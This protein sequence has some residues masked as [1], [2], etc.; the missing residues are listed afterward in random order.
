MVVA[1]YIRKSDPI[2]FER[3]RENITFQLEKLGHRFLPFLKGQT[4]PSADLVWD[5]GVG[6]SRIPNLGLFGHH[7]PVVLTCHGAAPFV[8]SAKEKWTSWKG[9]VIESAFMVAAKLVWRQVRRRAAGIIAVSAYGADEITSV[10]HLP[11][12]RVHNIYHGIDHDVF[13]PLGERQSNNGRPYLLCVAQ[14]QPK[15]NVERI[16]AAYKSLSGPSK[17]D[18]ILL[19]P[20]FK[21]RLDFP[22]IKLLAERRNPREIAA[23]YRGAI[24]LVFPSLHETFGFPIVEAMACGCPV[25]T[26]NAAA[27]GEIAGQA[28]LLVDPRDVHDITKAMGTLL[29]SEGLRAQLRQK[30]LEWAKRYTWELS[31]AK[32]IAAFLQSTQRSLNGD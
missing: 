17:P 25:I 2:S 8:L 9:A 15:K 10:F 22:G 4:I 28:A 20:G 31:A 32:H 26:S 12:G 18:L 1:V 11:P 13:C 14:S 24:G 30:G 6:G 27:C 5:P 3:Y 16:V 7:M 29:G 23:W 21:R 19:L